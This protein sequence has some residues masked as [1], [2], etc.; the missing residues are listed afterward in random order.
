MLSRWV[1]SLLLDKSYF[2]DQ[3]MYDLEW[4]WYRTCNICASLLDLGINRKKAPKY[5]QTN[6]V[7]YL[8]MYQMEKLGSNSC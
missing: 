5:F 8:Y 2:I 1:R 6:N 4:I 3:E 7:R